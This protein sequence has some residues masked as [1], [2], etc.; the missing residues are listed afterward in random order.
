LDDSREDNEFQGNI[1]WEL[2]EDEAINIS[3]KI[4][5]RPPVTRSDYSS[6]IA[7]NKNYGTHKVR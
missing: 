3:S 2:S 6:W 1:N 5:R 4:L 7:T